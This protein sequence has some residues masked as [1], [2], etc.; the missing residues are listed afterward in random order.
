MEL[1]L[2]NAIKPLGKKSLGTVWMHHFGPDL[3]AVKWITLDDDPPG[4]SG[5]TAK[6]KQGIVLREVESMTVLQHPNIVKLLGVTS[7]DTPA[8][9][10][11]S[12]TRRADSIAQTCARGT[13]VGEKATVGIV[14]EL[15]H[16]GTLQVRLPHR[17]HTV[18]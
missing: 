3:A 14:L 1:L 8:Q 11:T 13:A 15:C 10:R 18:L 2:G 7:M 17:R 16:F 5:Y 12:H 9:Q 4:V 6:Q